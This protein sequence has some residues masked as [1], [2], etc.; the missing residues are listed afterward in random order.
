VREY[1]AELVE[2]QY[3]HTIPEDDIL[4]KTNEMSLAYVAKYTP[5]NSVGGDPHEDYRIGVLNKVVGC[6]HNIIRRGFH[7][8]TMVKDRLIYNGPLGEKVDHNPWPGH[9]WHVY[10]VNYHHDLGPVVAV[11]AK[12]GIDRSVLPS[13]QNRWVKN[14]EIQKLIDYAIT[15]VSHL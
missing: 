15:E 1:A 14:P 9:T 8:F 7:W 4:I 12:V 10:R 6:G 3:V 2:A 5:S 13:S 11:L